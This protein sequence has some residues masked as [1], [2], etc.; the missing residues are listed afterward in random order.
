MKFSNDRYSRLAAWLHWIIAI[1]VIVMIA[2]GIYMSDI[3]KGTPDRAFFFNLHKSIG[4]TTGLLVLVRV[5]WRHKNP[6]PSLPSDIPVWQVKVSRVSHAALYG[7]LVVMPAV[8]FAASQFTKYGVTYFGL[9]KIPPMGSNDPI[10]RDMLQ[11]IHHIVAEVFI[12]L[13]VIHVL[14]ALYHQFV[15]RDRLL[16]RMKL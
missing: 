8:G 3:P 11:N 4:L 16:S 9:F 13:I 7:C 6:P 10:T 1:L 12:V 15:R 5:W 14:A 2:M